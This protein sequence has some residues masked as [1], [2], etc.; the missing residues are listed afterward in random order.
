MTDDGY[1]QHRY[2]AVQFHEQHVEEKEEKFITSSAPS[3]A[4]GQT[5]N[6]KSIANGRPEGRGQQ[7]AKEHSYKLAR[8]AF[9]TSAMK[10]I[11]TSRQ[12]EHS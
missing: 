7:R 10:N 5:T 8:R 12:E 9:P 11:S 1:V 3:A 2:P 6:G 4:R